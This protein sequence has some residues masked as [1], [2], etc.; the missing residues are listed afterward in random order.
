VSLGP[1]DVDG[2][3]VLD[4]LDVRIVLQAALGLITLSQDQVLQADV[5]GDGEVT[6]TDVQRLSAHII[7]IRE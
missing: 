5:D 4:V 2:S 1:G 7:G 6:K 3:G